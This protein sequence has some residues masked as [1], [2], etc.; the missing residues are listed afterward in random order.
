VEEELVEEEL[1]EEDEDDEDWLDELEL[2]EIEVVLEMLEEARN[3]IKLAHGQVKVQRINIR[4]T[5]TTNC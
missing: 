4:N 1:D 5:C 2:E 3:D